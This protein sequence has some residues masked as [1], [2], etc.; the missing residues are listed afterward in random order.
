MQVSSADKMI[1]VTANDF[2]RCSVTDYYGMY[3]IYN[4]MKQREIDV[5]LFAYMVLSTFLIFVY[6]S[7]VRLL[8]EVFH[9]YWLSCVSLYNVF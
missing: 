8:E 6:I 2:R 5:S 4:I 9:I 7:V 3:S 1:A